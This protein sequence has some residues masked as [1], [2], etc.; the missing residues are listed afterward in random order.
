MKITRLSIFIALLLPICLLSQTT[1]S[2]TADVYIS[3]GTTGNDI[4][5]METYLKSYR[6]PATND[7]YWNMPFLQFNLQNITSVVGSVKLRLYATIN[8]AHGFDIYTTSLANWVEDALTY[9]NYVAFT[10][11]QS[12]SPVASLDVLGGVPAQYTNGM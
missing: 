12:A 4:R 8:E 9:N 5:S 2:P 1:F 11:S 7:T 10:G 3:K 6:N